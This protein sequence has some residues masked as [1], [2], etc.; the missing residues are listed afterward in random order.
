MTLRRFAFACPALL[1][2]FIFS[3]CDH[4]Q[5]TAPSLEAASSASPSAPSA[6]SNTN[7]V[8][9]SKSQID[10][11][12]RDNATNETGF[13]VDRSTTGPG[14]AFVVLTTTGANVTASGDGGLTALTQY[15]YKVRAFKTTGRNTSYS[16]FS[17]T[18]CATTLGPPLAPSSANA[19]P[20]S[21]SAVTVTWLDNS[22]TEDGFR[23]ERSASNAGPWETAATTGP[24]VTSYN[25]VGR[26]SEQPVCYRVTAFNAQGDSPAS[27]VDCTTP[28]A[29]PTDLKATGV[30]APAVDLAWTDQ[31]AVEDGYRVERSDNGAAFTTVGYLSAN[32]TSYRDIY[33]NAKTAY[34]YQVRAYKDG[35]FSG[36][37]NVASAET[38]ACVP[39]SSTE[40]CDNGLDDDCDGLIDASDPDCPLVQDCP[41]GGGY[42]CSYD[43]FCYPS[44]HDGVKDGYETDVD[45]GAAGCG[46]GC[47][48]GQTCSVDA[49]CASG[50]CAGVCQPIP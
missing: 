30:D 34:A 27:N 11:S 47:G 8:A 44:C 25:D 18:A 17:T 3:G 41:C 26:A 45:C 49:D 4:K 14:G 36:Y 5:P 12:W 13:E 43:G 10:V 38:G 35:A 31:S 16:L 29:A 40:I 28:P 1:L 24:N 6:P 32:I 22:G 2:S 21:S 50:I 37:S 19:V 48:V 20:L 42:T 9:V 39:T 15:C 33:V 7:A 46:V 23:V